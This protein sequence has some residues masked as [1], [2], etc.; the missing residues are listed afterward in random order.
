[1]KKKKVENFSHGK[2]KSS[3]IDAFFWVTLKMQYLNILKCGLT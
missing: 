1:M 2:C 3:E